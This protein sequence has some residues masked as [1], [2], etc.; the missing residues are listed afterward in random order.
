MY[1]VL[2]IV[3]C[4][5]NSPRWYKELFSIESV[6]LVDCILNFLYLQLTAVLSNIIS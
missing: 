4:Y 3:C 5:A 2:Y 1:N 6:C